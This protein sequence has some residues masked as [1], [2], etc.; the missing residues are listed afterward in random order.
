[1]RELR[2]GLHDLHPPAPL[3][4]VSPMS[5]AV[6]ASPLKRS[7]LSRAFSPARCCRRCS[8]SVC[9]E[10]SLAL[11]ILPGF[12][13]PV[14]VCNECTADM[15]LA[16]PFAPDMRVVPAKFIFAQTQPFDPSTAQHRTRET[17]L[18]ARLSLLQLKQSAAERALSNADAAGD[19]R[20]LAAT[21]KVLEETRAKVLTLEKPLKD[22]TA[23]APPFAPVDIPGA[24]VSLANQLEEELQPEGVA[25]VVPSDAVE[26]PVVP[27]VLQ[28]LG[29]SARALMEVRRVPALDKVAWELGSC[30]G[31][32]ARGFNL[33]RRRHH[34]RRC[35]LC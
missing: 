26:A 12:K 32:C 23:P 4:K 8:R 20:C 9:N 35:V 7:Q 28:E 22:R 2:D 17:S 19:R 24:S 18:H 29:L 10:D 15:N 33:I 27:A 1:V 21:S 31:M 13:K 14:R 16:L 3:P 5:P 34:C 6:L 30:C 11:A 25:A